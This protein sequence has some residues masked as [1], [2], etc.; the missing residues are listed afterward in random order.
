MALD[1]TERE[2]M[3]YQYRLDRR[4]LVLDKLLFGLLVTFFAFIGNMAVEHNRESAQKREFVMQKKLEAVNIIRDSYASM[5]DKFD[6]YTLSVGKKTAEQYR[7][8][9]QAA[10]DGYELKQKQCN[11][12]LSEEFKRL[13]EAQHWI[14]SGLAS[15]P[16]AE[17]GRYRDF[18]FDVSDSFDAVSSDEIGFADKRR[19]TPFSLVLWS[20]EEGNRKG[21]AEYLHVNYRKWRDK[22]PTGN[23]SRVEAD[24]QGF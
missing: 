7:K 8:E 10:L 13:A 3:D 16:E 15:V 4:K 19:S 22:N 5:F 20:H 24:R 21:S 14:F 9:F 18:A 6:L 11:T 12:L 2:R 1:A 17:I 23:G